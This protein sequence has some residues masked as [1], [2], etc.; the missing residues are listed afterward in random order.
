VLNSRLGRDFGQYKSSTLMRRVR[1]R[2]Q[3]LHIK[4]PEQYIAQLRSLPNEPELLFREIL[5]GVTRFFPRLSH[6]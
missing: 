6:V 4:D 1:R 2:M 5:I 3:V